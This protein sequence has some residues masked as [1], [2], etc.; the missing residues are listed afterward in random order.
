M[1]KNDQTRQNTG[2]KNPP[3][4]TPNKTPTP[5]KQNQTK[6]PEAL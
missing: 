5:N 1:S 4:K 2:K 6:L 3:K